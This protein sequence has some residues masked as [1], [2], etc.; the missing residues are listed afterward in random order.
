MLQSY[1]KKLRGSRDVFANIFLGRNNIT[2]FKISA[3]FH[4]CKKKTKRL[5]RHKSNQVKFHLCH[6]FK[7]SNKYVLCQLNITHLDFPLLDLIKDQ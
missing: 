1:N 3:Q 4:L 7:I 2:H 5:G 6:I